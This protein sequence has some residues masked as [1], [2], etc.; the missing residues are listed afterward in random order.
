MRKRYDLIIENDKIRIVS[1][2][3]SYETSKPIS[4]LEEWFTQLGMTKE[5]VGCLLVTTRNIYV[6]IE[7]T[8]EEVELFNTLYTYN[9]MYQFRCIAVYI[10]N[11]YEPFSDPYERQTLKE[12]I[13]NRIYDLPCKLNL[14]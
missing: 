4:M 6:P 9:S 1:I 8:D 11:N 14:K 3:N 5:Y 7:L 10:N 12:I 13:I 2:D